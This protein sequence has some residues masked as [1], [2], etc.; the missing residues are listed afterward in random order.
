MGDPCDV[1]HDPFRTALTYLTVAQYGAGNIAQYC[2]YQNRV[3]AATTA[4][5]A[6]LELM[7]VSV[8][9]SSGRYRF[10]TADG[11]TSVTVTVAREPDGAYWVTAVEIS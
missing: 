11:A 10:S 2:V 7:P 3:P 8:T 1:A 6:G 4:R 5:L 9:A